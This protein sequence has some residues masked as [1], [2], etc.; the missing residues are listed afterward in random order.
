MAPRRLDEIREPLRSFLVPVATALAERREFR[1]HWTRGGPWQREQSPHG[2]AT[3]RSR[4]AVEGLA[5]D[6]LAEHRSHKSEPLDPDE[7]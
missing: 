5:D 7:L 1:G 2:S 6:A 3:E 4:E